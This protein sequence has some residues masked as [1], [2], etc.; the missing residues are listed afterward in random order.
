MLNVPINIQ[1]LLNVAMVLLAW[2]TVPFLGVKGI[3]RF[4]PASFLVT[5][6]EGINVQIGKRRKWW[7]FFNKPKSYLFGEFPFNIGP[8]LVGSLWILK[9]TFGNFTKFILLNA[10]VDAFFAF[11]FAKICKKIR[12]CKLVKLNGFQFFLYV[13]YKAFILYG[14]QYIFEK[15]KS[16]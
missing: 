3:I 8:H 15:R 11:P 10:I 2:L 13:F 5:L 14:L 7:V 6:I 9:L 16:L 1:R 12:Y 4:L